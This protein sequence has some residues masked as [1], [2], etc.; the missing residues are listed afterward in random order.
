MKIKNEMDTA[1]SKCATN[2]TIAK[3]KNNKERQNTQREAKGICDI[4]SQIKETS[5]FTG[6]LEASSF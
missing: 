3:K 5:S 4:I 1:D 6:H 2:N